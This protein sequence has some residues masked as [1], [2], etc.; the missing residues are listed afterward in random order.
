M[1]TPQNT[2]SRRTTGGR[3]AK[4]RHEHWQ[5][6]L[7]GGRRNVT[8]PS[9]REPGTV[10]KSRA[11]ACSLGYLGRSAPA[12]RTGCQGDRCQIAHYGAAGRAVRRSRRTYSTT[13]PT[14][15]DRLH[16]S[17]SERSSRSPAPTAGLH[18]YAPCRPLQAPRGEPNGE[19]RTANTSELVR[20]PANDKPFTYW[21]F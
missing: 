4:Y 7:S 20:T 18:E 16:R 14:R 13:F 19:P 2:T 12:K 17:L 8:P 5:G 10:T 21:T 6:S 1:A 11:P 15:P 3:L 9:W